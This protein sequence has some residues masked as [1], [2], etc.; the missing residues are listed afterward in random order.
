MLL[1]LWLFIPLTYAQ[2]SFEKYC[3]PSAAIRQRTHAKIQSAL[4][5]SD[6]VAT[7]QNCMTITMRPHRR[8]L[9]QR[10]I[11]HSEP[12]A[13]ID[14]SSDDMKKE[15]CEIAVEKEKVGQTD[16]R[17][18][19]VSANGVI[20]HDQQAPSHSKELMQIK[21]LD[22]FE[23]SI[24]QDVISGKCRYITADKYEITLTVKKERKPYYI[25]PI[26]ATPGT[27]VVVQP[28]PDQETFLLSTQLILTRGSRIEVGSAL[29][30]EESKKQ[31]ASIDPSISWSESVKN[32]TEKVYLRL[33]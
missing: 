6:V 13:R 26:V 14:F 33:N 9:I 2:D 19:Q 3:F 32:K 27:V 11:L 25:P 23:L 10:F 12:S 4:V 28:P 1:W 22:N 8:E 21:T 30:D 18:I 7:D 16:S 29:K 20:A 24:D 31:S 15:H 17:D 5:P